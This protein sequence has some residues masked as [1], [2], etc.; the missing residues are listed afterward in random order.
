MI[1]TIIAGI[2]SLCAFT[3][4]ADVVAVAVHPGNGSLFEVHNT[5]GVCVNGAQEAVYRGGGEVI[6]GCWKFMDGVGVQIAF[7]D[8]EMAQIPLEA[9]SEPSKI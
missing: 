8:G 1:K 4:Q 7:F 9:F 3:V 5:Q 2:L 6:K